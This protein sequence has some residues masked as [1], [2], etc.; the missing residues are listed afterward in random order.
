MRHLLA[1]KN[2]TWRTQVLQNPLKL[3]VFILLVVEIACTT[4]KKT[5]TS[6]SHP[7]EGYVDVGNNVRLFYRLLGSGPDTLVIIHG[8]PGFTMDYFLDDLAPL[9]ANH[10]LLFYDQR[11]AGRS[12]LVS[13]SVSLDAQ[14]FAE[15][16]EAI[17]KHFRIERLSLLGHSWG[18]AV[19]ALYSIRYPDHLAKMIIVGALPLQR[20]QLDDAFRQLAASRDSSNLRRMRELYEARVSDPGNS[21]VCR[22]YYTLWFEAF[23]GNRSAA[24]RSKGDFCA[25]TIDSRRNKINSVDKFTMASL[26]MW[27]WR[28][29]LSHVRVPVLVI[30][31]TKDPLPLE[32]AKAW[33]SVVRNSRLMALEGIGHFPY[34]EVPDQFFEAVNK[35]LKEN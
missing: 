24:T 22:A 13:D 20:Y 10:A 18:T 1:S 14:R 25:G 30:H 33:A 23:F 35:F 9:A 26:G 3:L 5:A 28:T 7:Q 4:T 17:R 29:S 15:D 32:G 31:G 12:T 6:L 27:D 11:G 21:D 19:E 34:L 8:G 2:Q 16:L